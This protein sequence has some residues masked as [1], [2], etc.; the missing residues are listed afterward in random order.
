MSVLKCTNRAQLAVYTSVPA[1]GRAW[2]CTYDACTQ[3]ALHRTLLF[4]SDPAVLRHGNDFYVVTSSIETT[5]SL[6]ILHS[7][8]LVNYAVVGSVSRHWFTHT[9]DG[10]PLNKRQCWSPRIMFIAG[11]FRIMWHQDGHFMV[12]EATRAEGPWACESG[13]KLAVEGIGISADDLTAVQ[14][15]ISKIL[16]L[17]LVSVSHHSDPP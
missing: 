14:R 1:S 9:V 8:D 3:E 6:Q 12:A 16:T 13:C 11:R 10:V 15:S 7:T 2:L 5:P 4:R 17:S